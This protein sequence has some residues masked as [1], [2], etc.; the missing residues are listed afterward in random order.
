MYYKAL[1]PVGPVDLKA[2][3]SIVQILKII[4]PVVYVVFGISKP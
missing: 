3:I 1:R 2:S 4:P